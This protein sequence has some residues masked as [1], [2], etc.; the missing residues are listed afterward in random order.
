[1]DSR[2]GSCTQLPSRGIPVMRGLVGLFISSLL[3]FGQ[4]NTPSSTANYKPVIT[5]VA[6]ANNVSGTLLSVSGAGYLGN[7]KC[8]STGLAAGAQAVPINLTIVVDGQTLTLRVFDASITTWT[9]TIQLFSSTAV[10]TGVAGD[11]FTINFNMPF[12]ASL[13][14]TYIG[15]MNGGANGL[16]C[17]IVSGVKI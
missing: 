14:M 5:N 1:M 2:N 17:N 8:V 16:T 7:I 6:V 13:V 15:V 9:N 11:N 10:A 12:G 4:L 3:A